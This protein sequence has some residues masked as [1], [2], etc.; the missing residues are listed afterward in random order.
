MPLPS[1][2]RCVSPS[3]ASWL[4]LVSKA[5][6][7]P[8]HLRFLAVYLNESSGRSNT[9]VHGGQGHQVRECLHPHYLAA[10]LAMNLQA[11]GD[12][13]MP[14]LANVSGGSISAYSLQQLS[15][16]RAERWRP[17][18]LSQKPASRP[19]VLPWV[20]LDSQ[21]ACSSWGWTPLLSI[22]NNLIEIVLFA[23]INSQ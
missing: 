6:D 15:H 1:H 5:Q 12:R 13:N 4:A 7:V 18:P 10:L 21:L 14:R 22:I 8:G 3:A 9:S 11:R 23:N 19:C 20:V 16:W 2:C 17:S